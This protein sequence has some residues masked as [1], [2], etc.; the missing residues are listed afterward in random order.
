MDIALVTVAYNGYGKFLEQWLNHINEMKI[1]P[2]RITVGLGKNHGLYSVNDIVDKYPDLN[3]KFVFSHSV[4]MGAI[5]NWAIEN[6]KNEWIMYMDIDD[7]PLPWAICEFIKHQKEADVLCP[8]WIKRG[9]GLKDRVHQST[10]PEE[11]A[12]RTKSR[13]FIICGSPFKRKF[14]ENNRFEAHDSPQYPFIAGLVESGAKFIKIDRPCLVYL[15]R[16]DSHSR[17]KLRG[18]D[19]D[20]ALHQLAIK[21]KKDMDRRIDSYYNK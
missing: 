14:W 19:E 2:N 17:T 11:M 13:G 1:K 9:L 8:A 18:P 12:G 4:A 7:I 20:R 5:R 10:T 6:T 16:P 3:I 21:T 15:R